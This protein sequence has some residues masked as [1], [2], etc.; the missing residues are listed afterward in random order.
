MAQVTIDEVKE[1]FET[2][3]TDAQMNAFITA[4]NL[5]VTDQLN[6]V[7]SAGL[8]KEIERYL[9]AHLAASRDQRIAR[10][11]HVDSSWTYQGQYGLGLQS[12][13]YGQ[14]VLML[15]T[16]GTLTNLGTKKSQFKVT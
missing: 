5:M 3:L 8:L 11:Q 2:D 1:V 4:A 9:A 13:D 6:G 14:H 10:E 7:H 12:T 16:S 15:D